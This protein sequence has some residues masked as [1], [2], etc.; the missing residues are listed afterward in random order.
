MLKVSLN[1]ED[2]IVVLEPQGSLMKE[3]FS[4]AVKEID[5]FIE[6]HGKLNGVIIYTMSF[7]GWEDFSALLEHLSFI[8]NH[9][10]EVKR[11]AF[12]SNSKIGLFAE[13]ITSHFVSAEIKNFKYDQFLQA[14][15]W[16]LSD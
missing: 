8:K 5:P 15:E 12:V 9:H 3:D 2:A 6:K 4:Q 16:I 14:K 13:H 7:P 10:K 11:L 1:K